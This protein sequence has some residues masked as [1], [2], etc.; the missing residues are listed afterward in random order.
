MIFNQLVLSFSGES[1]YSL[2]KLRFL[3]IQTLEVG[4]AIHFQIHSNEVGTQWPPYCMRHCQIRFPAVRFKTIYHQFREWLG[5]VINC[6]VY[7][8][9][10]LSVFSVSWM[11]LHS[12][13]ERMMC[14][15]VFAGQVKL[16][17]ICWSIILSLLEIRRLTWKKYAKWRLHVIAAFVYAWYFFNSL[18]PSDAY[19]RQ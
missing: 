6:W 3:V 5:K 13:N 14:D 9:Y 11:I 7:N 15:P 12:F 10:L 18:R 19:M 4:Y 1:T 2:C 17:Y 16:H 8:V